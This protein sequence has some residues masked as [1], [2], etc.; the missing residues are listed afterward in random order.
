MGIIEFF[1][2]VNLNL[3]LIFFIMQTWPQILFNYIVF[4]KLWS[5]REDVIAYQ[6]RFS[7]ITL[8][9]Y[10]PFIVKAISTLNFI[11]IG[12]AVFDELHPLGN[13]M[14]S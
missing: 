3:K 14:L 8:T 12:L 2:V 4:T 9:L 5:V 10:S 13:L 7:G 1:I 6:I 11:K